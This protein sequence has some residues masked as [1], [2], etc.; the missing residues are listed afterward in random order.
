MV[1]FRSV[2]MTWDRSRHIRSRE[3]EAAC[4]TGLHAQ[5][6]PPGFIRALKPSHRHKLQTRRGRT[7]QRNNELNV[8]T[9]S[10]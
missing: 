5:A 9:I 2:A 8:S 7:P 10:G 1:R 3:T 6:A 4:Q